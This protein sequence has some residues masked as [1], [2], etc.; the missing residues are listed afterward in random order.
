MGLMQ[1]SYNTRLA[2]VVWDSAQE[3]TKAEVLV[4][5]ARLETYTLGTMPQGVLMSPASARYGGP[6]ALN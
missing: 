3:Q 4:A 5:R 2:K 1:V 6:T